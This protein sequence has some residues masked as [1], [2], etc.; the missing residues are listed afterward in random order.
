MD[1]PLSR[2]G[3]VVMDRGRIIAVGNGDDLRRDYPAAAVEN[4][5]ES[6]IL[7]GL[8][9]AH[10]HLELSLLA[11]ESPPA[12]FVHW[13][14]DLM[15]RTAPYDNSPSFSL[16]GVIEGVNQCIRFGVTA[17]GDISRRCDLT[18]QVLCDAAV[19]VVSYGEVLAM[20]SRRN[21]LEPRLVTAA[22]ASEANELLHIGISPH[23]PYSVEAHG[24]SRCLQ[25]ARERGMP[26]AT[27][28]AETRDEAE[29]LAAHTGP[30]R[31]LWRFLGAWDD[32]V[33]TFA[34][35]PIRYAKSLGLLDYPTLLA[36]VNYCDDDELAIL[37]AGEASVV[38]CPRTHAYFGHPPHR[39]REMLAAGINVAVGTDS[40]ASSPDLNLV[41]DLRLMHQIAPDVSAQDLWELAT[42]RAARAIGLAEEIGS[43]TPGKRADLIAFAASG[44]NPL[45]DILEHST[46]PHR[47]WIAGENAA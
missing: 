4:L 28:L 35:G 25:I 14:Q 13:V 30:F 3:G 24:Y 20:A 45:Q 44:V 17:V 9:N 32:E 12:S 29:F 36:H 11:P 41:D 18:R 16:G 22:D 10:A 40:C 21:L 1:R 5:G 15:R 6:I 23:A 46:L 31:E 43:L 39:W 26:L 37:A 27:H 7:P 47:I 2:D 33:P 42:L 38:Y 34:G 8:V 19:R